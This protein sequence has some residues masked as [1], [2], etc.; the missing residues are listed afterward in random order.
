MMKLV[1]L[2]W[3]AWFPVAVGAQ[4]PYAAVRPDTRLGFPRDHGAHPDYRIEW[5]YVTGWLDEAGGGTPLG[6]QITFFRLRPRLQE[7]NPSA[8]AVRQLLF[9]HAALADPRQGRLLTAEKAARAGFGL[10]EARDDD[11]GLVIDDWSLK[12]AQSGGT[13]SYAMS[14]QG[15]GFGYRLEARTESPPVLQGRAGFSRKAAGSGHASHYYSR[16][17][18]AVTG[19]VETDGRRIAVTGRAWLDHEWSSE[20]MPAGTVGWD[21]LGINLHDG[22]ALMA[23]R[24]RGA[25]GQ[26]RWAGGLLAPAGGAPRTLAPEEVNFTL[27]RR[28]QSPRT[29][30]HYPVAIDID[31]AGVRLALVPLFDDQEL[32]ARRSVGAVYWE[33]AVRARDAAGREVGRGYL[34]LTGYAGR[35][36]LSAGQRAGAGNSSRGEK[37]VTRAVPTIT[38]AAPASVCQ[39]TASSRS[40]QPNST[41]NNG[42]RK[43][44]VSAGAA[45]MSPI[46][47][48]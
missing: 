41:P 18:L 12:R 22:G 43:V 17:Q 28:W 5:W 33:G 19:W 31:A 24:M 39:P 34:E 29:G 32:D 14:A 7:A 8:F 45:P 37:P 36:R 30:A 48:K 16:P 13:D 27:R 3:L 44:T 2:L 1:A 25:D 35:L 10:A 15:A 21:W 40:S 23:F 46:R 9:A 11:T 47:R 38:T 6:F 42:I 26:V 20:L 4:T